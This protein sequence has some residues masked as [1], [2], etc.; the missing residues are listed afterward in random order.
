MNLR[1]GMQFKPKT[2]RQ[3]GPIVRSHVRTIRRGLRTGRTL[4]EIQETYETVCKE[5]RPSIRAMHLVDV[6]EALHYVE[7]HQPRKTNTQGG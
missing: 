3:L 6:Y 5:W 1:D 4:P 7:A 2:F